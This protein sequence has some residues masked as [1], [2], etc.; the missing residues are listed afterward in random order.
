M[1]KAEHPF[2]LANLSRDLVSGGTFESF[3]RACRILWQCA[4]RKRVGENCR[5]KSGRD[6]EQPF[7]EPLLAENLALG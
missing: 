6:S 7:N 2:R 5:S 4:Q 1:K 3:F